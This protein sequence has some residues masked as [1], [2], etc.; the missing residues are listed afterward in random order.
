MPTNAVEK[1]E[2]FPPAIILSREKVALKKYRVM[3][4]T[5]VPHFKVTS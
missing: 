1:D 2:V 4:V 5:L 3:N